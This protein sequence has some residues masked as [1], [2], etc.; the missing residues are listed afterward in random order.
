[1][2]NAGTLSQV[3]SILGET[4]FSP[5]V[6]SARG[7]ISKSERFET[8]GAFWH[9]GLR[10]SLSMPILYNP[11]PMVLVAGSYAGVAAWT[12]DKGEGLR[13]LDL[14]DPMCLFQLRTASRVINRHG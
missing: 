1:M 11:K 5:G 4:L 9:G 6:N 10:S 3:C 2:G 8:F 12:F 14:R 13:I 7:M